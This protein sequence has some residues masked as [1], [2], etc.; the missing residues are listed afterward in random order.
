[1]AVSLSNMSAVIRNGVL[2][3]KKKK[4]ADEAKEAAAHA[5]EAGSLSPNAAFKRKYGIPKKDAKSKPTAK[6]ADSDYGF[7]MPPKTHPQAK[8]Y[9]H[10]VLSRAHQASS[11]DKADVQKQVRKANRVLYGVANPTDK[12][13][14]K[15]RSKE[16]A[17]AAV[18]QLREW[19]PI[20]PAGSW[21]RTS[22]LITLA[23]RACPDFG[24]AEGSDDYAY[25]I[26][27][28]ASF[29]EKSAVVIA[30]SNTGKLWLAR[31]AIDEIDG[32]DVVTFPV[33]KDAKSSITV[34]E[35]LK[36]CTKLGAARIHEG[37]STDNGSRV[38]FR[39][40]VREVKVSAEGASAECVMLEEGPGN[41]VDRH[42][43]TPQCI[44]DAADSGVFD[45][46]QT[47]ADHANE[48]EERIQ[49]G[50][51]VR[52]LIGWWSDVHAEESDDGRKLLVGTFM[53][54]SG[55]DWAVNKMREAKR[56]ASHYADQPEKQYVGFSINAAGISE[57][58]EIAGK[59]YNAVLRITEAGS[60]DMVTRA[61]AGGRMLSLKEAYMGKAQATSART[62]T[63]K[64]AEAIAKSLLESAK[65]QG[66]A[67]AVTPKLVKE[68][69]KK[70]KLDLNDEQMEALA[71]AVTKL[72]KKKKS[73]EDDSALEA[74]DPGD[75]DPDPDDADGY[76]E[77]DDEE[78]DDASTS[79]DSD[80]DDDADPD[81]DDGEDDD[82][83]S[84][85]G[86][87]DDEDSTDD[88]DGD[89][90]D[91]DIN[92]VLD[93]PDTEGRKRREDR[94]RE[95]ARTQTR[96]AGKGKGKGKKGRNGAIGTEPGVTPLTKENAKLK[97]RIATLE[98]EKA[99]R[100]LTRAA[101]TIAKEMKVPAAARAYF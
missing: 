40:R 8:R 52:D 96:E 87:S 29:P 69:A 33:V 22:E 23:A 6:R 74:N 18:T 41:E 45:G 11:F 10:A 91:D 101:H 1:M 17:D 80:D 65:V 30:N 79:G 64:I 97:A 98:S 72:V 35:A 32:Q 47:F 34:A 67:V 25:Y 88:A 12:Q 58:R 76:G 37:A 16:A 50:R 9:A 92:D 59:T 93:K 46:A 55:N 2:P 68:A 36:R 31:Y 86:E 99:M 77:D 3:R 81:E 61:G 13:K 73:A 82:D 85:D 62:G 19:L 28:W 15:S 14:S 21:E 83:E 7:P 95:S 51:S 53:I 89:E 48:V 5:R 63:D 38:A 54:E 24:G 4:P 94:R 27:I 75:E 56:Y 90:D 44:E 39:V 100:D 49:P 84:A 43:Y 20:T 26:S 66:V 71:D 60:T 57:S 70:A 78:D 42:Y